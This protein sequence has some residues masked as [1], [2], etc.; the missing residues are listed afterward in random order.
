MRATEIHFHRL[1][2]SV[3]Q[4]VWVVD[5]SGRV[6]YGN[7]SWYAHTGIGAGAKFVRNYVPLLHPEDRWIV[8]A[9]DADENQR[10]IAELRR[11]M[12]RKDQF[13][14]LVAHELRGPLSPILTT[15]QLPAGHV[16]EPRLVEIDRGKV[17]LEAAVDAA[18]EDVQPLM[19]SRRHHGRPC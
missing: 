19:A 18:I 16:G 10:L 2:D 12:A 4:L 14:A 3:A 17:E 5:A 9:T 7:S 8:V 1:A 15:L 11:S 6:S 13:V